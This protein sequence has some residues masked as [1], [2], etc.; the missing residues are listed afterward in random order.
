[1]VMVG[2]FL[3]PIAAGVQATNQGWRWSYRTLGIFNA[4]FL[5]LFVFLY[6][7][8]KY[9]PAITGQSEVDSNPTEY[10]PRG[11]SK[12]QKQAC[13]SEANST[14]VI[15]E[16]SNL[17]HEINHDIAMNSWRKRLALSTATPE[18]IWPYYYRPFQILCAFPAVA[19][20]ALQYASGVAFLTIL[21]SVISLTFPLPPYSFSPEQIGFMSVGPFIGNLIGVSYGGILGDWSII[22]FSRKNKGYFEPEMRLYIL[23]IPAVFMSGGLMMFGATVSRGMHWIYPSIA[24]AFFGF[25]LGSISDA[26]LTLVIDSYRELTGDAFTGIAFM[27]NAVSIGIPFA[28]TPWIN[29]NGIQNMFIIAGFISLGITGLMVPVIIWGK[30]ARRALA[31][32]YREMVRKQGHMH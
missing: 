13:Q 25:G 27:R 31:P 14:H 10:I 7:E 24:G 6:E 9:V 17:H 22:Y 23:P 32:H 5:V 29:Q 12:D 18:T 11:D 28:I 1:M 2:S 16:P 19:Y 26:A 15:T 30:R 3:G 8:T 21:S 4:I 20:T